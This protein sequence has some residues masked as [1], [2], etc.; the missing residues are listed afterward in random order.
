MKQINLGK[1][2]NCMNYCQGKS[3]IRTTFKFS[4]H[5]LLFRLGQNI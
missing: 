1:W 4:C 3:E 2:I 5:R